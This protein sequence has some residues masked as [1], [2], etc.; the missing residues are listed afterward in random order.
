MFC[1]SEYTREESSELYGKERFFYRRVVL[2]P[3]LFPRSP[4]SDHFP[5]YF[6]RERGIPLISSTERSNLPYYAVFI[7]KKKKRE[8]RTETDTRVKPFVSSR[9]SLGLRCNRREAQI[10]SYD[11]R[12]RNR[13][14]LSIRAP[15]IDGTGCSVSGIY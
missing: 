13:L 5:V 3:V 6:S 10:T 11:S 12:F 2:F 4:R 15:S 1:L 9:C 7:E 14:E 8:R